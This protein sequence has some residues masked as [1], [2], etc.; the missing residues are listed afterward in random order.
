[1]RRINNSNAKSITRRSFIKNSVTGAGSVALGGV[2]LS[3][4][5]GCSDSSPTQPADGG[6]PP[7]ELELDLNDTAY[8]SL[9]KVGGTLA[10]NNNTIDSAGLLLYRES[11][12]QIRAYSRRCT[13]QGCTIGPFNG[14]RSTCPCHGSV[15]NTTGAPV[16]GPAA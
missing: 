16:N 5:S 2:V 7:V 10:L 4:I 3:V 9:R 11:N 6:S 12:T 14:G 1:M 15:F 13:H 8:Q